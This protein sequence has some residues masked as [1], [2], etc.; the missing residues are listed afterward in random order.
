MLLEGEDGGDAAVDG[1][2]ESRLRLV[3]DRH[4]SVV[5]AGQ[6]HLLQQLRHVAGPKHFVHRRKPSGPL[7]RRKVRR[8]DAAPHTLAPQKL[9]RPAGGPSHSSSLVGIPFSRHYSQSE[10]I[11]KD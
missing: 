1:V 2:G 5:A 6:R 4:H 8:K 10:K 9:A 7:L 11:E 3:R